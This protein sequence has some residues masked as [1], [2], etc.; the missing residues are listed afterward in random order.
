MPPHHEH[1][2]VVVENDD[3]RR[4]GQPQ[5]VLL[6]VNAVGE[7]DV[8]D[9]EARLAGVVQHPLFMDDPLRGVVTGLGRHGIDDTWHD[10]TARERQRPGDL[11]S[12]DG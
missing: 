6:E 3:D 10:Q 8:G 11:L 2:V 9:A 5:D 1:L 7:L 4:L 12:K